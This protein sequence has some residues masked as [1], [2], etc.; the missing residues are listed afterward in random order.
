MR[1][2]GKII[3]QMSVINH[4][5]KIEVQIFGLKIAFAI[6]RFIPCLDIIFTNYLRWAKIKVVAK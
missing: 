4:S 1:I 3:I 6:P 5:K 2:Y